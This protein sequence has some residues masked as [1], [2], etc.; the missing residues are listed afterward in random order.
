MENENV[1]G[2][3]PTDDDST[4]SEGRINNFREPYLGTFIMITSLNGNIFALLA[5]FAGNSLV[6]AEFPWQSP[7]TGSFDV[8]F[9]LRLN[10]LWV[11]RRNASDLRRHPAHYDVT[12]M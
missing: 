6:T 11:N 2:A 7:V 12:V 5:L 4:T 10:K 1:V 3:A 8:F 9:D